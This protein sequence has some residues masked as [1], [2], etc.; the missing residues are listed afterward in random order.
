MKALK[1]SEALEFIIHALTCQP[2]EIPYI[3]GPPGIGKS[4]LYEQVADMF[5][6]KLITEHLSQKLPEDLTGM[7][8]INQQTGKAEYIPFDTFPMEGD[9]LPLDEDGEEMDGWLVF[10]D[11]LAD[12][13]DEILSAI[14]SL[15]L[16]HKV[17]GK[18]LH[19]KALLCAAGNRSTDS[20]MARELPD[21]LITRMLICEMKVSVPDWINWANSLDE[22]QRNERVVQYIEKNPDMLHSTMAAEDREELESY[23]TPRGWKKVMGLMNNHDRRTKGKNQAT[24]GLGSVVEDTGAGAPLTPAVK[25]L[26]QS[27]VGAFAAKG[28]TEFYEQTL[29][30]P[31]A[32]DVAAQPSS[33]PVP[34]TS[35]GRSK[36]TTTLA[37]YFIDQE[38]AQ[39]SRDGVIQFMNRMPNENAAMFVQL[40]KDNMADNH[41]SK[42][43]I[44]QV[45]KTLGT[46]LM[47]L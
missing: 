47:N 44:E 20:A 18:K 6:L 31:F 39:S 33:V 21:T 35:L 13:N 26:T 32:W 14:Y 17:G 9:P 36:L 46:T 25:Q 15:L 2:A 1:P 37:T 24:D 22:T 34:P 12:A 27:A 10:L 42:M 38:D 23:H 28:F 8:T 3:A 43:V 29:R 41:T 4:D 11:E 7:P 40:L 5:N 45:Q 16:G 30:I 19:P